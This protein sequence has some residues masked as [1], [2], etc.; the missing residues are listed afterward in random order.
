M[1]QH[2][3]AGLCW[4]QAWKKSLAC[5]GHLRVASHFLG[6][7]GANELK[8]QLRSTSPEIQH[9]NPKNDGF[10]KGQE[11]PLFLGVLFSGEPC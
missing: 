6:I 7:Q 11:S 4:S 5:R 9:K 3:L 10:Q 2:Q 1:F 8:E